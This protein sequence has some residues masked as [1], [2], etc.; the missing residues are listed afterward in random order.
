MYVRIIII[1]NIK[2]GY[3]FMEYYNNNYN[4]KFFN[5]NNNNYNNYYNNKN[6]NNYKIRLIIRI[7]TFLIF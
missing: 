2:P 4:K 6:N 5:N 3:K 1:D 7:I